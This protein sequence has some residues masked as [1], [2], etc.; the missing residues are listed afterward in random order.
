MKKRKWVYILFLI[1]LAAAILFMS[2]SFFMKKEYLSEEEVKKIVT[3][4]YDGEVTSIQEG[5]DVF[6][7]NLE[8]NKGNYLISVQA[9]TGKILDIKILSKNE[10]QHPVTE[11]AA[12]KYVQS[13]Y[14]GE[15]K[16]VKE[17]VENGVRYFQVELEE[18]KEVNSFFVNRQSGEISVINQHKTG[19]IEEETAEEIAR[20]QVEG[21]IDDIDVE[22][23]DNQLVYEINMITPQKKEVTIYINAYS[24]DIT[25]I[26][27]DED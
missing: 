1:L 11:E 27:W 13:A 21:T 2:I 19:M 20:E 23:E 5:K 8:N 3:S 12:V 14:K 16:S 25:S 17:V 10:R 6:K 4:K 18:N 22:E 26:N 24:G 7:A 9:M 15:L